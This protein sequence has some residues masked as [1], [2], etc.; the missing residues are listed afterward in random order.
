MLGWIL[1]GSNIALLA[2][3]SNMM[4]SST[5]IHAIAENAWCR[6]GIID[7]SFR[8]ILALVVYVFDVEG[9]D[10]SWE[11]AEECETYVDEEVG[12]AA[13]NKSDP[14]GWEEESDD[15][16][17]NCGDHFVNFAVCID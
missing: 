2:R 3:N 15:Y 1:R 14:D 13:G 9:M 16:E 17:K 8:L 4:M 7:A 11:K 10:M 5:V 12:T 6:S